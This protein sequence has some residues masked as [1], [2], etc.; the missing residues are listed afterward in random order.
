MKMREEARRRGDS[1]EDVKRSPS[2]R[3]GNKLNS[4][5]LHHQLCVCAYSIGALSLSRLHSQ[6]RIQACHSRCQ[7]ARRGARWAIKSNQ[8]SNRM[9]S[10]HSALLVCFI[11]ICLENSRPG[12]PPAPLLSSITAVGFRT[13]PEISPDSLSTAPLSTARSSARSDFALAIFSACKT[14][15]FTG[16]PDTHNRPAKQ[17]FFFQRFPMRLAAA[18]AEQAID[19]CDS[20]CFGKRGDL[21]SAL[22]GRRMP[23]SRISSLIPTRDFGSPEYTRVRHQKTSQGERLEL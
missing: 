15:S 19:G 20:T 12:P 1:R 11:S 9:S 22:S 18:P 10:H 17:T 14:F 16:T 5:P 21:A 13:S 4:I 7:A 23:V 3:K 2:R 8:L 6:T